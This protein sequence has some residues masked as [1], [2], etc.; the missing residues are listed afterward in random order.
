VIIEAET[1]ICRYIGLRYKYHVFQTDFLSKNDYVWW[2]GRDVVIDG[3]AYYSSHGAKANDALDGR[4]NAE[5]QWINGEAWLVSTREIV[6]GEEIFVAYGWDYW[7]DHPDEQLRLR[8]QAYYDGL[9]QEAADQ[10]D[11]E[12]RKKR[13]RAQAKV[14]RRLK[15][16]PTT[17]KGEVTTPIPTTTSDT[18]RIQPTDVIHDGIRRYFGSPT[19]GGDTPRVKAPPNSTTGSTASAGEPSILGAAHPQPIAVRQKP[20]IRLNRA[21]M[22]IP[23][24]QLHVEQQQLVQRIYNQAR[25]TE[26]RDKYIP[27]PGYAGV[28]FLRPISILRLDGD[29]DIDDEV[30]NAFLDHMCLRSQRPVISVNT[31]VH[32]NLRR[33]DDDPYRRP[34]ANMRFYGIPSNAITREHD[35]VMSIHIPDHWVGVIV[36]PSCTRIVLFDGLRGTYPGASY[37]DILDPLIPWLDF[38]YTT[39]GT[40]SVALWPVI[41]PVDSPRQ[42]GGHNCGPNTLFFLHGWLQ[43]RKLSTVKDW[44]PQTQW[45]LMRDFIGYTLLT[46]GGTDHQPTWQ[47]GGGRYTCTEGALEQVLQARTSRRRDAAPSEAQDASRGIPSIDLTL[48]SDEGSRKETGRDRGDRISHGNVVREG[49]VD[50][51]IEMYETVLKPVMHEITQLTEDL[52]KRPT[53]ATGVDHMT[54]IFDLPVVDSSVSLGGSSTNGASSDTV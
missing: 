36:Q 46:Q 50:Q 2:N 45:K 30:M 11:E 37:R 3:S 20:K 28:T 13:K 6:Q 26:N 9:K 39:V 24:F 12:E 40:P 29:T 8:A 54:A 16:T 31:Y 41:Y 10:E 49:K 22:E 7:H 21:G 17:R 25:L 4:N 19:T 52:E 23:L 27:T 18:C 15:A 53:I 1:K 47:Q 51:S 35:M 14:T 48:D 42:I 33:G 44:D 32:T 43:Y 5:I 34:F 38:L